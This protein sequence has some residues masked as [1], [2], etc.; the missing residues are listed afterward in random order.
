MVKGDSKKASRFRSRAILFSSTFLLLPTLLF[1]GF[2]VMRLTRTNS[3][4]YGT[5]SKGS[6]SG[7]TRVPWSGPN[8]ES[9]CD[10]CVLALRTWAHRPVVASIT[11]AWRDMARTRPDTTFLYG[12]TGFPW[13]GRFPPHRTHR[14]G[15]SV[16]FMVPLK[17]RKT[18]PVGISNRFGYDIAFDDNGIMLPPDAGQTGDKAEIDFEAITDHLLAL[19]RQA[20]KQGGKVVRVFFAPGLQDNLRRTRRG[21]TLFSRIRFNKNPSWVRHDDHY[22]VDFSFPCRS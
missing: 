6:L 13:G 1:G 11:G 19:H 16:D 5:T 14:N 8:F 7:G 17:D 4:C 18:L 3:I 22:H 21:Q 10:I 20:R 15:L 2:E 12:E 9:Y